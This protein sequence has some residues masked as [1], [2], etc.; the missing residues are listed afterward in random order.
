MN[1]T[2]VTI[3]ISLVSLLVAASFYHILAVPGTNESS[4][5][6]PNENHISNGSRTTSSKTTFSYLKDSIVGTDINSSSS[7]SSKRSSLTTSNRQSG[8][9]CLTFDDTFDELV[10]ASSNVYVTM[11]SKAAGSTLNKFARKCSGNYDTV[12]KNNWW[13][14]EQGQVEDK[15]QFF[16]ETYELPKVVASHILSD[17]S[18]INLMEESTRD[19]LIIYSYRE[20][21]SRI[22][23]AV[24]MILESFVCEG[25]DH[26]IVANMTDATHCIIDEEA[27]VTKIL[28]PKRGELCGG[29]AEIMTNKFFEAIENN[30]PRMVFVHYK[31]VDRLQRV[32]AKHH[33]PEVEPLHKNIEVK[34]K[35]RVS[36][37][38]HK[39]GEVVPMK[40]W[41]E[42]KRHK[43]EWTFNFKGG[44]HAQAKVRTLEDELFMCEDE[45]LMVTRD[46]LF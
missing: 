33:C 37:K 4:R 44:D 34:K 35:M 20:E 42:A 38:L 31:Q 8:A 1:S 28:Q 12:R 24:E 46:T 30:F 41:L 16:M 5:Q 10:S 9:Q 2:F 14:F 26:E 7:S 22:I 15:M 25:R 23:S 21:T 36:V 29:A 43:I 40:E 6:T 13:L 39:G 18:M 3:A 27:I 32:L 45:L 19:S 17:N 11:P